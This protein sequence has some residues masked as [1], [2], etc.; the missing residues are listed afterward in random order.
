MNLYLYKFSYKTDKIPDVSFIPMILRRRLDDFG[1][2]TLAT[3]HEIY[4]NQK[5][6]NLVFASNC[7]DFDRVLKLIEQKNTEGEI[8]P[9]GFSFSVHNSIVGLFSLINGINSSYNSVSAGENTL[10]AGI[11]ESLIQ[12][13]ETL[14]CYGESVGGYKSA[15]CIFSNEEKEGAVKLEMEEGQK[16]KIGTFEEFIEFLQN[17]RESFV[18]EFFTLKRAE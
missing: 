1:K 8:S 12:N 17:E 7:G 5:N 6:I 10:A 16:N 13:G 14:F 3:M 9:V 2:I 18:S 11:L 15:A 4:E